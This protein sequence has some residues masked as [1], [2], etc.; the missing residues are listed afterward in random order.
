MPSAVAKGQYYQHRTMVWLQRQGFAVAIAQRMLSVWTPTGM[1]HTKRDQLGADLIAMSCEKTV[2][3]QVKGGDTWRTARAAARAEFAR[4][5]LGPSCEQW[6]VG[7]E[8][9]AREPIIEVVAVGPQS[10]QHVTIVPPRR[11]PKPLPLFASHVG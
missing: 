6:L 9:R 10:A 2:A 3:I 5:P 7:W 11:K 1:V 4:Y 8:P